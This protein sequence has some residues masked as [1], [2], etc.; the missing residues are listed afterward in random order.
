MPK[1]KL[2]ELV[3]D[4]EGG[5]KRH[6]EYLIQDLDKNKFDVILALSADNLDTWNFEK[7]IKVFNVKLGDRY[8]PLV[9]SKS[10][11]KLVQILKN[12]HV[13]IIHAHGLAGAIIGTAASLV[14]GTPIILTTVHNFPKKDLISRVAGYFLRYNHKIITVS[15]RMA[16]VVIKSWGIPPE[17]IEVIHNGIDPNPIAKYK[18]DIDKYQKKTFSFLNIARLIPDKGVD[19]FLKA[20]ALLLDKLSSDGFEVVFRIAGSGPMEKELKAFARELGL[21]D[22]VF[23]LGFCPD[24]YRIM[25]NS[26]VLVL[27]SR[28]EGLSLS[29]LEAMAMGKPVIATDVG[30]NPE[31]VKH[32]I[33]GILVPPADPNALADAMEYL[34]KNPGAAQKM[35]MTARQMVME[36]FTHVQMVNAVQN[37]LIDLASKRH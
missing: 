1:I 6:V 2:L 34:I 17:K 28:S 3:R 13:E 18:R 5:M 11:V 33:T 27:S 26:D 25:S 14:A 19:I 30:G 4:A 24:I 35:A 36:R 16:E 32:G 37:L 7:S 23:F 29:L 8:N 20:C 12:E 9:I 31:I 15:Q 22:K 21:R 10:F